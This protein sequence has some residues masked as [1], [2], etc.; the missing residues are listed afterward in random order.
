MPRPNEE[1]LLWKLARCKRQNMISELHEGEILHPD[2]KVVLVKRP[3]LEALWAIRHKGKSKNQLD[4][5]QA[6]LKKIR[7]VNKVIATD[8]LKTKD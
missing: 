1:K 4:D 5:F 8:A 2:Q 3:I 7:G 6:F